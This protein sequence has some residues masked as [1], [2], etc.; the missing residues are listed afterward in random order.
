MDEWEIEARASAL[1]SWYPLTGLVNLTFRYDDSDFLI[2]DIV[3]YP[4]KKLVVLRCDP[5]KAQVPEN[6]E[7][8]EIPECIV[9]EMQGRDSSNPVYTLYLGTDNISRLELEINQAA[10]QFVQALIA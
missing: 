2:T 1:F 5:D 4:R 10:R 3:M 6:C 7:E 8:V 9:W